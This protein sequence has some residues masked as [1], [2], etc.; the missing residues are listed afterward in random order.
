MKSDHLEIS[1]RYLRF[2]VVFLD[3]RHFSYQS[4]GISP[5]K[6]TCIKN[7]RPSQYQ[8]ENM[9]LIFLV[10][11]SLLAVD[12]Y[13]CLCFC[14]LI[15]NNTSEINTNEAMLGIN[16]NILFHV[17]MVLSVHWRLMRFLH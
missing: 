17:C 7:F 8:Y 5:N 11:D 2:H 6:I 15:I 4:D 16:P 9:L 13:L 12:L 1:H 14:L 3:I 10:I